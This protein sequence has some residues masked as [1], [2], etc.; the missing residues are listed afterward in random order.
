MVGL[1]KALAS[2]GWYRWQPPGEPSGQITPTLDTALRAF[3]Q[4][5]GLAVD[6]RVDP[7]GPTLRRLAQASGLPLNTPNDRPPDTP[8]SEPRFPEGT[9][10]NDKEANE[11]LDTVCEELARKI[12]DARDELDAASAG[13][14][15][16]RTALQDAQRKNR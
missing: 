11:R 1:Q 9:G 8:G 7:D 10:P 15:K 12:S 14:R 16:W 6:G 13:L 3:Q 4:A 5:S 2:L